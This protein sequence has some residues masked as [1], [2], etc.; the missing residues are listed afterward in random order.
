MLE[1]TLIPV[2]AG[3]LIL[4]GTGVVHGLWTERWHKSRELEDAVARI[5]FLPDQVG[6]WKGVAAC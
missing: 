3:V 1:F 5:D 2:G 4:V 6:D